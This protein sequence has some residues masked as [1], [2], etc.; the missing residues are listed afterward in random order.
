MYESSE[1]FLVRTTFLGCVIPDLRKLPL[2]I[3]ETGTDVRSV[4]EILLDEV[5][6]C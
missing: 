6:N 1:E 4:R 5:E 3:P 2:D